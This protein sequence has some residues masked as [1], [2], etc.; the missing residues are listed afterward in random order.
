MNSCPR[1]ISGTQSTSASRNTN[2]LDPP[3]SNR[4]RYVELNRS[5]YPVWIECFSREKQSRGKVHFVQVHPEGARGGDF[6]YRSYRAWLCRY[7]GEQ[8]LQ[9][10]PLC[11]DSH[12]MPLC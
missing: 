4:G 11:E 9:R 12:W 6:P 2:R 8:F 7:E 3:S 5:C 10:R 1:P